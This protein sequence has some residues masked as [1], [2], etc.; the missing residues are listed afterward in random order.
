MPTVAQLQAVISVAGASEAKEQLQGV[1]QA[2]NETASGFKSMMGDALKMVGAQIAFMAVGAAVN[3]LTSQVKDSIQLAIAQ[4]QIMTQTAAAIKSTGDA[5]GMS[6][7]AIF[8]LADSLSQVTLFSEPAIQQSE[9]LLLTFTT[10]G[11]SVFPQATKAI[12]D[13]SQAMGEDLQSATIQVGKALDNPIQGMSALQRIGVTFSSSQK[14]VITQMQ[15]TGNI[16]GAQKIILQ[17]LEKEFGNSATA[18]GTTFGGQ[19]QIL[20]NR[21]DDT[22]EKIAASVLPVLGQLLS[23]VGSNLMPILDRFSGW[24]TGTAVPALQHFG[25][26]LTGTV[27]PGF[28]NAG[29]AIAHFT[30]NANIMPPILAAIGTVVAAVVVPAF[31]AWAAAMIANPVGLIIVGIAL[32]VAGLTAAFEHFYSTNAGF[33]AVIDGI[34]NA[35]KQAGS[36]ISTNFLPVMNDIGGFLKANV[37]PIL[38]QVGSFIASN[39]LPIWQQLQSMW[40]GQLLPLFKQLWGAIQPLLPALE[41]LGKIVG[42]IVV[43]AL[44]LLVGIISGVVK[45]IAGFLSGLAT[46][47][48]GIVQLFTGIVQVISG[49]VRF[50]YDLL[51]GNFGALKGDLGTIWDG[52]VNIFQGAWTTIVG[53]FQAVGGT[54]WGIVSGFIQG[55]IGFFQHLWDEVVGHSIIPDMVNGIVSWLEQLLPRGGAAIGN[56]ISSIM[57][58]LGG[59]AG[60]AGGA[61]KNA[62]STILSDLGNAISGAAQAGANIVQAIAGG[63]TSAIGS[64]IG[65]AMSAVGNFI[66]AHLPHSPA[67]MGPLVNLAESGANISKQIAEG[68]QT[69]MPAVQASLNLMLSPATARSFTGG[70]SPTPSGSGQPIILTLD[71]RAIGTGLLPY[72]VSAIRLATGV[73]F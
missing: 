15:N 20:Q 21:L 25:D 32:A 36:F 64:A 8:N 39:F 54:I 3:F 11:K 9:N 22:K 73:K 46:A 67:K 65:G 45:G 31:V 6:A 17:E 52:I 43:V 23:Y 58:K 63:I 48:G 68:M 42:G 51:T 40:S 13:V 59:L 24:F 16:A 50:L 7:N 10:I 30:G 44:G 18:A 12:L 56:M 62:V 57:G 28:Q 69:G 5:S 14:D 33:K 61:I 60:Q 66:Q 72:T 27:I 37:L 47:I 55:V 4:Q 38:Q 34:G 26:Y 19:L 41:F 35:F 29:A 1:G 2:A 70:S 49:I 71:G 53:I